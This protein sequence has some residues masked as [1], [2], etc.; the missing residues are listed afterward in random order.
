MRQ[1]VALQ[2]FRTCLA[3]ASFWRDSSSLHFAVSHAAG[4]SALVSAVCAALTCTE[5]GPRVT[6]DCAACTLLRAL[7]HCGAAHCAAQRDAKLALQARVASPA[8]LACTVHLAGRC[9]AAMSANK[10]MEAA[11]QCGSQGCPGTSPEGGTCMVHVP[12]TH[13][14]HT[15]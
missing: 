9:S 13:Y 6:A 4:R 5:A 15:T 8:A 7:A 10:Y 14:I 2:W 11:A 12:H 3:C 1:S